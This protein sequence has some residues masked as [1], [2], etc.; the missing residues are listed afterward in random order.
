MAAKGLDTGDK[1]LAKGVAY[2]LI[3]VLRIQARTARLSEW[4]ATGRRGYGGC[5]NGW[6]RRDK[7]GRLVYHNDQ[8]SPLLAYVGVYGHVFGGLKS[9]PH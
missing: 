1:V 3:H 2:R 9:T 5:R 6:S 4:G 7:K 8:S